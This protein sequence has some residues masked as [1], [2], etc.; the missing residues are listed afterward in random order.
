MSALPSRPPLRILRA[1]EADA[2]TDG[3][4]FLEAAEERAQQLDTERREALEAARL[5]G[6]EHGR[7]EG[8]QEASTLLAETRAKVD[9]YLAGL[10]PALADLSLDIARRLLG[11]LPADE[12]L[13]RLTRAALTEFRQGQPLTLS[14]SPSQLE[15]VRRRLAEAGILSVELVA[16]RTLAP[17]NARLSS[18][19]ASVEVGVEAQLQALRDALLPHASPENRG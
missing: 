19:V 17:E 14:L 11:E 1:E 13:Y 10:E 3:F 18:A 9:E 5:E 2:W 15:P 12:A 4:A 16:D 6:Y 7:A 8:L